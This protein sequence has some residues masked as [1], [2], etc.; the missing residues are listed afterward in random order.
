[1]TQMGV[2]NLKS[3]LTNPARVYL[4]EVLIPNPIGGGDYE[5]LMLRAQSTSQPE[6]SVGAINIPFKQSAGIVYPG[7]LTYP[8]TWDVTFVEGED[9]AIFDAFYA[10]AQK[11]VHDKDNVS[12]GEIKTNLYLNLV[13]TKGDINKRI[14]L[15]G[16]YP[17]A[18]GAVTLD[19]GAEGQVALPVTFA[20]DSWEEVSS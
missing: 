14:K 12:S 8:H 17:Q 2:T 18:I 15:V 19:Y 10:W 7:K 20:Y 11:I 13:D 1:M 16:C 3:N 4:W 9:R 5:T 6:R